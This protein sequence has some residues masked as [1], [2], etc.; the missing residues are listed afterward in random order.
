MFQ[1]LNSHGGLKVNYLNRVRNNVDERIV[2]SVVAGIAL[3][4]AV[5]Y[6]A[7]RSGIKPLRQ[8]AKVAKG[9]K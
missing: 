6:A 1:L 8:A 9:G 4:G 5:T 3:F 7:V 2:T